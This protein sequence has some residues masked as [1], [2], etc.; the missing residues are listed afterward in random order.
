M[1]RLLISST[2]LTALLPHCLLSSLVAPPA[3]ILVLPSPLHPIAFLPCLHGGKVDLSG[4]LYGEVFLGYEILHS[5]VSLNDELH[6]IGVASLATSSSMVAGLLH[7]Q[8]QPDLHS[9][10]EYV[11]VCDMDFAML[12]YMI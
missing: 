9:I 3:P 2:P 8:A 12:Q 5:R 1:T 7:R 6:V 10:V 4:H 11:V